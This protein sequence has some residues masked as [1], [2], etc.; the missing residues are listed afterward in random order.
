MKS[1]SYII[2]PDGDVELVLENPNS[3]PLVPR[4]LPYEGGQDHENDENYEDGEDAE[5]D[6]NL[7]SYSFPFE[8]YQED[9]DDDD[10]EVGEGE[11][12]DKNE[13]D[14]EDSMNEPTVA[15]PTLS[16][17]YF[18]FDNLLSPVEAKGDLYPEIERVSIETKVAL[19][20]KAPLRLKSG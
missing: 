19:E 13:E 10:G 14:D 12:N 4:I 3:Q 20:A 5:G 8:V 1:I 7:V 11:E 9:E 15:R 6:K 17:R 2:D 16:E 18:V